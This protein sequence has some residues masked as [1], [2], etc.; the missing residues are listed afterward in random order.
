VSKKIIIKEYLN[1]SNFFLDNS[2]TKYLN[3]LLDKISKEI[4]KINE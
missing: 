2:K 3:A 1:A 4:R